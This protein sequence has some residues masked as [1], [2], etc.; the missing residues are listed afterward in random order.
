MEYL[1][2]TYRILMQNSL[3]SRRRPEC[4]VRGIL[5]ELVVKLG[6]ERNR[7]ISMLLEILK[8]R[9]LQRGLDNR[10]RNILIRRLFNTRN[11][12]YSHT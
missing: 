10:R 3:F 7:L 1:I 2:C 9:V 5:R 8:L 4:N 6:G 11:D 12:M